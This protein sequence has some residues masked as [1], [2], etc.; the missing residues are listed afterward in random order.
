MQDKNRLSN[1]VR[2]IEAKNALALMLNDLPD[3]KFSL[4]EIAAM[5]DKN[6][7]EDNKKKLKRLLFILG[8]PLILL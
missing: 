1:A 8:L 4:I 7:N 5:R 3:E 6:F 2:Y